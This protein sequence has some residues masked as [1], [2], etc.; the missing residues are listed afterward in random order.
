MFYAPS[1]IAVTSGQNKQQ[2]WLLGQHTMRQ[3]HL[4]KPVLCTNHNEKIPPCHPDS[5]VIQ[6]WAQR[7]YIYI[8]HTLLGW[9][10]DVSICTSTMLVCTCVCAHACT[11][12]CMCVCMRT[13]VCVCMCLCA[14]ICVCTQVCTHV[15][16]HVSVWRWGWKGGR[17]R[18]R[19]RQTDTLAGYTQK[20]IGR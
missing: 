6:A 4:W 20:S 13:C 18:E 17:V 12:V 19:H 15:C 5:L 3:A 7:K 14:C 16:A 8:M 2:P 9:Q 1:T 10:N 11:C